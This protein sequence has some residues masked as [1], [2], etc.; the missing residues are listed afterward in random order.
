[1]HKEWLPTTWPPCSTSALPQALARV[2]HLAVGC[3]RKL[4]PRAQTVRLCSPF[5]TVTTHITA[6]HPKWGLT[7]PWLHTPA[8]VVELS[9]HLLLSGAHH[10]SITTCHH[11]LRSSESKEVISRYHSRS[12]TPPDPSHLSRLL[13]YFTSEA[14]PVLGPAPPAGPLPVA[15]AAP[16][17]AAAGSPRCG[18]SRPRPES[19]S[20]PPWPPGSRSP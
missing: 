20:W 15:A 3:R 9:V 16:E 10:Q 1:M 14:S 6:P 2:S 5:S 17:L 19:G 18:S 8:D 13:F 7:L 4:H 12:P 11:R